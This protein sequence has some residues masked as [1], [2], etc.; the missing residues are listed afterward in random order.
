MMAKGTL[1]MTAEEL[2]ECADDYTACVCFFGGDPACNPEH[3]VRTS[4]L[5]NENRQI[6]V[7]YETNGNISKKWLGKI[8]EIIELSGG[9]LKFDLKAHTP[10]IYETLTGISN[11][12][13]LR[14]FESIAV[15]KR[16]REGEFLVASILLVPGYIDIK[17]VGKLCL[18]I[19]DVDPTIPTALLGF[20]PHH[21]MSDLPRTSKAHAQAALSTAKDVGLENVRIGN[22]GLLGQH[23]YK[24]G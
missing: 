9:T 3:S 22:L 20:S 5:L 19:A 15:S 11:A 2:S 17:E 12:A 14:N 13:I 24:Y 23:E 1:L 7:C 6:T 16:D 21:A 18:F 4:K 10:Q 8:T